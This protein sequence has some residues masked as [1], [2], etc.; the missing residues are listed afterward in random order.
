MVWR[1]G[2]SNTISGSAADQRA[3]VLAEAPPLRL[4]LRVL[5]GPEAIVGRLAVDDG[6]DAQVVEQLDLLGRRDHADRRASAVEH[7]LDGVASEAAAG[8][9]DEDL[10]TLGHAGA[11]VRHQHPVG[12]RVAQ[13]VDGRLFPAEVRRLGHQ[14]VRLDHRD[15]GQATEVRLEA[16]DALVGRQHGIVVS[17]G[18]LVVDVVAVDGDLVA[19]LPVPYGRAGPQD[20]ARGVR[21]DHV[22]VEGVASA[23]DAFLG[24]TVEEAERRQRLEDRGPDRVEV[25]GGRQHGHVGLVRSQLGHRHLLHVEGLARVLVRGLQALEHVHV[26]PTDDGGPVLLGHVE[27]GQLIGRGAGHHGTE[28]VAHVTRR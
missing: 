6:L 20:N 3:D 18:V 10:V 17:R 5:V 19:H 13:R 27:F 24:Q 16:P 2:C 21:A 15:V 26:A 1:P 9:P 23:P 25:D 7:V 4:V 14:L 22:V 8:P 12:G 28:D 11:V